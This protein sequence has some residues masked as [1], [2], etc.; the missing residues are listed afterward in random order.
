[1]DVQANHAIEVTFSP[2]T[3]PAPVTP[4]DTASRAAQKAVGFVK[5][6]DAN[7]ALAVSFVVLAAVAGVA[8]LTARRRT[9]ALNAP[10]TRGGRGG[11]R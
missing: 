4:I 11:R 1:M 2:V 8:A 10:R 7:G 6:G 3:A 5:T 9:E